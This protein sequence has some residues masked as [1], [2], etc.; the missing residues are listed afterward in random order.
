MPMMSMNTEAGPSATV[1]LLSSTSTVKGGIGRVLRETV[2]TISPFLNQMGGE[3]VARRAHRAVSENDGVGGDTLQRQ[4]VAL[5][6]RDIGI[7]HDERGNNL[8]LGLAN[9]LYVGALI[10]FRATAM[11]AAAAD[12][13]MFI[14][15]CI[16]V[17][18][19]IRTKPRPAVTSSA[20][21][22]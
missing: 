20:T 2:S 9:G 17:V 11:T 4:R 13:L 10:V 22:R 3:R 12:I 21:G 16:R 8:G 7:D 5:E 15:V 6:H 14:K 19:G 18:E 1:I